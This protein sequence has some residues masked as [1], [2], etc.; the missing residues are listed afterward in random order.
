VC[1]EVDGGINLVSCI[2]D[3]HAEGYQCLKQVEELPHYQ[4]CL[5]K[6]SIK[7]ALKDW[8]VTALTWHKELIKCTTTRSTGLGGQEPIVDVP[9]VDNEE[10][11]PTFSSIHDQE[12]WTNT[13]GGIH[14]SGFSPRVS[15][16][17]PQGMIG[18]NQGTGSCIRHIRGSIN[19]CTVQ[20]LQCPIF[21]QCH[22][23][24][25]IKQLKNKTELLQGRFVRLV[26][27]CVQGT[28][29]F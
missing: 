19:Q 14:G 28:L 8:H 29:G 5:A 11:E 23:L 4:M 26:E 9:I 18:G 22:E 10:F 1:P 20:A 16:F 27:K 24:M 13:W 12:Q 3:S 6:P 21:M 17:L 7:K 15:P 25:P 2:A